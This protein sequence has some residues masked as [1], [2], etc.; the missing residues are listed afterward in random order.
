ML[1]P[2]FQNKKQNPLIGGVFPCLMKGGWCQLGF[3]RWLSVG[4]VGWLR[5][6]NGDRGFHCGMIDNQDLLLH[7]PGWATF[8]SQQKKPH[9]A[10]WFCSPMSSEAAAPPSPGQGFFSPACNGSRS[11]RF[12]APSPAAGSPRMCV[13][14]ARRIKQRGCWAANFQGKVRCAASSSSLQS[15]QLT[16]LPRGL[17]GGGCYWSPRC[18]FSSL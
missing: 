14:D 5:G 17:R 7:S 4:G 8:T 18:L 1:Q 9:Q 2:V 6:L 12:P 10:T 13:G 15:G 16:I 3:C 11:C